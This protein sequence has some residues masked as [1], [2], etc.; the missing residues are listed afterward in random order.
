MPLQIFI[1][2]ETALVFYTFLMK[3]F[4]NDLSD[5]PQHTTLSQTHEKNHALKKAHKLLMKYNNCHQQGR[6]EEAIENGRRIM[7]DDKH[8]LEVF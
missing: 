4:A 1:T 7:G 5:C 8:V 3:T 2:D 6:R